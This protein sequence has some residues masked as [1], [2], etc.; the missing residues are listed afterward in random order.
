[1]CWVS[2]SAGGGGGGKFFSCALRGGGG[3]GGS[4]T[5][6]TVGIITVVLPLCVVTDWPANGCSAGNGALLLTHLP[7]KIQTGARTE[8]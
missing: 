1:V 5:G 4:E 6:P 8:S 7:S 2:H 3:G